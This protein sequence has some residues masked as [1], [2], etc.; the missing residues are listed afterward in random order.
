MQVKAIEKTIKESGYVIK[1]TAQEKIPKNIITGIR[2]VILKENDEELY[3]WKDVKKELKKKYPEIDSHGTTLRI[4][5]ELNKLSQRKL[6]QLSS[7]SQ[8]RIS[9]MESGKRGIGVVQAKK[10]A[11]ILKIDYKKFL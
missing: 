10:L 2:R 4:Y 8:G 3:D 7:V 1:I 9:D 5:R 6:A 11:Q